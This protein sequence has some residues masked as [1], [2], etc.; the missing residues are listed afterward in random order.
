VQDELQVAKASMQKPQDE[1][2]AYAGKDRREVEFEEG[3]YVYLSLIYK[4]S[5]KKYPQAHPQIC[6]ALPN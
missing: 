1:Q 2:R 4:I 3:Q 6:G 5:H